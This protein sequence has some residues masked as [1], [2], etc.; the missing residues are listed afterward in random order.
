MKFLG[1]IPIL[2]ALLSCPLATAKK[3][4]CFELF[5]QAILGTPQATPYRKVIYAP[6]KTL[7]SYPGVEIVSFVKNSR[8]YAWVAKELAEKIHTF[9]QHMA[10]LGFQIPE[11]TRIFLFEDQQIR[12]PL[13]K[14]SIGYTFPNLVW[15]RGQGLQSV[16]VINYRRTGNAIL[17]DVLNNT[18]LFL[19]ERAHNIVFHSYNRYAFINSFRDLQLHEAFA[20]FFS[21]HEL[22]TPHYFQL[23]RTQFQ[24]NFGSR[25]YTDSIH[26]SNALWEVRQALDSTIFSSLI[27][28]FIDNLSLYRQSF[29][30][31]KGWGK[32][33]IKYKKKAKDELEFFLA[34]LKRTVAD[35]KHEESSRKVDHIVAKIADELELD[36][37][38]IGHISQT[39][40]KSEIDISYDRATEIKIGRISIAVNNAKMLMKGYL[41]GFPPTIIIISLYQAYKKRT[42]EESA[43][44]PN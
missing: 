17:S 11:S 2:L 37:N 32:K 19:H 27:K 30:D 36:F 43:E 23:N 38:R 18:D 5:K 42:S 22:G 20:D 35:V 33:K 39:I 15:R 21:A 13:I 34:V 12:M 10:D 7:A 40:T 41:I 1:L 6:G 4:N 44:N 14:R 25:A 24:R 26:Y 3:L 8:D 31:L 9:D 28:N 29:L 16:I